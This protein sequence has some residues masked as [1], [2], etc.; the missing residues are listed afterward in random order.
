MRIEFESLIIGMILWELIRGYLS[1]VIKPE[2]LRMKANNNRKK[3]EKKKPK[4]ET[5]KTEEVKHSA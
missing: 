5:E 2:V 4:T 1:K 3:I